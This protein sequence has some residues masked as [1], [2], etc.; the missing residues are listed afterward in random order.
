MLLVCGTGFSPHLSKQWLA[1]GRAFSRQT[2]SRAGSIVISD[3]GGAGWGV[4]RCCVARDGLVVVSLSLLVLV[5][6]QV[7]SGL[8]Q[9]SNC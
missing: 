5:G 8:G 3:Q 4:D 7:K 6:W 9:G 1:A 2:G